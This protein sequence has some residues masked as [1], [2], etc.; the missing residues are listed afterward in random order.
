MEFVKYFTYIIIQQI[1]SNPSY[2][3]LKF[4]LFEV[5]ARKYKYEK[6]FAGIVEAFLT[7]KEG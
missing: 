6:G 7:I 2:E 3:N 1:Y 4:F 5:V